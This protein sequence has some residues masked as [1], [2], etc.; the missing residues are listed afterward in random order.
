MDNVEIKEEE[1]LVRFTGDPATVSLEGSFMLNG[2][3]EYKPVFDLLMQSANEYDA[4]IIDLRAMEFLNSSG[5]N[6]LTRF[7]IQ[8][9][10]A[11]STQLTVKGYEDIP[12]QT[13]LLKNLSRL[14]PAITIEYSV[15]QP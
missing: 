4:V 1:Y 5:I 7:V 13:R 10:N 9:R 15:S 3:E 14:L 12:W 6:T 8:V 11:Q 2:N